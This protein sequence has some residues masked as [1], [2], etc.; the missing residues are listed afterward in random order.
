MISILLRKK[1]EEQVI[2]EAICR[3]LNTQSIELEYVNYN[4][5]QKEKINYEIN[6]LKGEF[7]Y[8]LLIYTPENFQVNEEKFAS[9]FAKLT[10]SDVI[11]SDNDINPYT[12]ILISPNGEKKKVCQQITDDDDEFNIEK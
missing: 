7:A 10:G 5:D 11:I 1:P 9:I 4:V 12:W 2:K 8:N 6:E 3:I